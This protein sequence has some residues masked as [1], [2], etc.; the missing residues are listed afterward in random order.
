MAA[1]TDRLEYILGKKAADPLAAHFGMR[2]VNDSTRASMCW[3]LHEGQGI[4]A[5]RP[6]PPQCRHALENTICPRAERRLPVP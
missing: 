6:V 5:L 3:P 2:T 4:S 1:L